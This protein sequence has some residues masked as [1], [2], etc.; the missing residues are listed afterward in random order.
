ME[1]QDAIEKIAAH[2][3]PPVVVEYAVVDGDNL[4]AQYCGTFTTLAE[5][6]A[7]CTPGDYVIAL[8]NGWPRAL[9]EDE[10]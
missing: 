10:L 4:L 9:S 6:Q 2:Y 5:A 8:E 3:E 1:L 7:A